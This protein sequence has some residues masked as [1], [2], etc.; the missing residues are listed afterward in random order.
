MILLNKNNNKGIIMSNFESHN[1]EDCNDNLIF[2][3]AKDNKFWIISSSN[4]WILSLSIIIA[5]VVSSQHFEIDLISYLLPV[6]ALG[7]TVSIALAKLGMNFL[8]VS[9]FHFSK[10]GFYHED[11]DKSDIYELNDLAVSVLPFRGGYATYISIGI[12]M[13]MVTVYASK[14]KEDCI[15]IQKRIED[16]LME[17]KKTPTVFTN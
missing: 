2:S 1:L 7:V 14:S 13:D 9:D 15:K 3:P 17:N 5:T 6:V 10:D 11:E 4:Y 16:F 12:E 8:I